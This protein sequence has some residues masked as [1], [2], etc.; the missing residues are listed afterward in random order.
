LSAAFKKKFGVAP[1]GYAREGFSVR[2]I[3]KDSL[4]C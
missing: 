2:A 3:G 4:P 1:K